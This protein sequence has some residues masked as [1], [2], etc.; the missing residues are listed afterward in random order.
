MDLDLAVPRSVV[1][2]L[3]DV[4][5]A[6]DG[7][8]RLTFLSAAWTTLTG[9]LVADS[10]GTTLEE[11]LERVPASGE[12]RCVTAYGGVRWVQVHARALP[13]GSGCGT[14]ADVTE[15]R[16]QA[17]RLSEAE[18]RFRGAFD[19]AAT[20]MAILA[21][22][23]H[24]LRVNR[25]LCE[26]LGRPLDELLELQV[27][28]VAHPDDLGTARLQWERLAAGEV[29]DVELELRFVR[30]DG[31]VVWAR[32]S[33]ALVRGDDG[34]PLYAVCQLQDVTA[35]RRSAERLARR[36]LHDAG[37]GL[38]SE[39]LFRDRLAQ[40]LART[41][42]SGRHIG[43]LRCTVTGEPLEQV[44][45]RLGPVLRPG[46]TVARVGEDE[47]AILLDSLRD[48][49]EASVV[50]DRIEAA[51]D[52]LHVRIGIATAGDADQGLDTAGRLVADAGAHARGAGESRMARDLRDALAHDELRLAFQP[53][54]ALA[55]GRIVGLEALLRW[56]DPQHGLRLPG[57]F[58]A[59][60]AGCGLLESFGEWV[61]RRSCHALAAWRQ[62]GLATD[63]TMSVNL[64]TAELRRPDLAD[65]VA[66]ALRDSGLPAHSLRLEVGEDAIAPGA[67]P[68]L[69]AV[70]RLGVALTVDDFGAGTAAFQHVT[71]VPALAKIKVDRALVRGA[72]VNREDA[73]VLAA[74]ISLGRSLAVAVVAEGLESAAEVRLLRDLGC[75]LGQG[76]WF[77]RPQPAGEVEQLL[78]RAALGEL[79]I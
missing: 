5:F 55:D 49:A 14:I 4:V 50:A 38:P 45:S 22:D 12:T 61:L 66:G 54:V 74:I 23:G 28:Q 30:P 43:V 47:L 69:R 51:L 10:L 29:P 37:T 75:T 36:A 18:A 20:G 3:D 58:L 24:P 79:G 48:A 62:D 27:D 77:G 35:A 65:V 76:F 39:A 71:R 13:D 78:R 33:L 41:R 42:R 44:A 8:G 21:P 32:Q 2:A 59:A 15:Q 53:V 26:L 70:A 68:A 57:E 19:H 52:D 16:R 56:D 25:A 73:A 64:S 31:G 34:T 46:D 9:R 40:A 67:L 17:A 63:I 72:A 60:A 1:D 6:T 11:H 7:H